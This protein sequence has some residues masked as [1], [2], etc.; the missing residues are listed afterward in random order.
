MV[1]R[2]SEPA[3]AAALCTCP[4]GARGGARLRFRK[5]EDG[6]F[7]G[8]SHEA[9]EFPGIKAWE[10][11]YHGRTSELGWEDLGD[12]FRENLAGLAGQ[13]ASGYAPVDPKP[14]ACRYCQL[15]SLCRIGAA[16]EL[17]DD[18]E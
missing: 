18:D 13:F 1:R 3:P 7:Q 6:G 11:H 10:V 14:Q 12:Y 16:V 8:I 15:A 2:P 5:T 4:V 9:G 17:S